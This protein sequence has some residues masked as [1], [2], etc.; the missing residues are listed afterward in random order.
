MGY[1]K[2]QLMKQME[3]LQI[4]PQGTLLVHSSMK[5]IGEVEGGAETVLEVLADYMKE[6]LL[7]LPT[8][9]WDTINAENPRFYLNTSASCV[10]LLTE[11][12]RKRQGVVRAK[13]PTHSVAV[14]G[15]DAEEFIS[16]YEFCETPCGRNSPWGKLLDRQADI[17]LLGV[18]LRKN[19][20][21]HGVEEWADIPGRLSKDYEKLYVVSDDG[22]EILV[23]SRRHIGESWSE[24]F[25]KVDEIFENHQVMAKGK[26]GDAVV[27]L[28]KSEPMNQLLLKMLYINP[29]L[30]S[31][32]TPLQDELYKHL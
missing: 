20:F 25:W 16:G 31:D 8:H 12:F 6:G 14:L 18:D 1:T 7:V 5:S 29:N 11:L 32:N 13:H 26:F 19:T 24:Y 10:G 15:K 23:H 2:S 4:N 17:M 3:Q 22:S 21:I 9:T 30:F 27:R 28:C